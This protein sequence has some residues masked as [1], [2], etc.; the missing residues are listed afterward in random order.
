[1]TGLIIAGTDTD[2]GKTVFAAMLTQALSGIY[3]KP[4]QAGLEEETDTQTVKRLTGLGDKHFLPEIYKLNTPASPHLAAE[5]DGVNIETNRLVLQKNLG[6]QLI[7]ET[8]GGLLVPLTRK[9]L[10]IEVIKTWG[11]PVI[12]CAR[13]SLGTIN[14][15]L[16]SVNALK[17]HNIPLLGIAFIGDETEDT[18]RTI[19]EFSGAKRLG[20]L[21]ILPELSAQTLKAAFDAQFNLRDFTF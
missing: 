16:L 11:L 6:K 5:L 3:F 4:I 21:N 12:L 7:V 10:Q 13:T 8:A 2:I 9:V 15:T 18:Q 14:H 20:R 1:M 19:I 17:Q